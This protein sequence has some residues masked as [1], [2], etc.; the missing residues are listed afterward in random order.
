[1][2]LTLEVQSVFKAPLDKSVG[3]G[4]RAQG[5][6]VSDRPVCPSTLS[7][8]ASFSPSGGDFIF[9]KGIFLF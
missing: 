7:S 1:M 9:L 6:I 8:F 2:C 5:L 3:Q 4:P